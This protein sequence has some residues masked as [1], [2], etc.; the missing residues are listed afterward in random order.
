LRVN[1]AR[2]ALL[3]AAV[4]GCASPPPAA[5]PASPPTTPPPSAETPARAQPAH[6]AGLNLRGFPVAFREGYTAG[7][8]SGRE[9]SRRRDET[10]Y[11]ADMNY[12]MGWNDGYGIC[13]GRR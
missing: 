2:V 13:A 5:P 7:C 3:A 6:P 12:M 9:G 8:E 4:A 1:A 10:R 11:K